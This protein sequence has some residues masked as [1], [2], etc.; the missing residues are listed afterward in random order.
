[1]RKKIILI[2]V[3]L[4]CCIVMLSSCTAF[5]PKRTPEIEVTSITVTSDSNVTI[6]D[7]SLGTLQMIAVVLPTNATDLSVIWSVL[8]GT[9]IA[10]INSSGLLTAFSNG[11]VTVVATSVGTHTISGT[12]EITITNQ[13]STDETIESDHYTLSDL[14]SDYD[15]FVHNLESN[16][17]IFSNE[18]ELAEIIQSQRQLLRNDMTQ[19]EF[20]RVLAVVIAAVRCGHSLVRV[21]Q[22][23]ILEIFDSEKAY[24]IDVRLINQQLMVIGIDG[25]TDIEFGDEILSI[26]GRS[27]QDITLEMMRY[28]NADGEGI[29]LK[30]WALSQ[31][32]LAYYRLFLGS[33]EA[34]LIE[35]L[36]Q[37]TGNHINT[38][39]TRNCSNIHVWVEEPPYEATYE[40]DYAILTLRT[41][42]PEGNYAL[43][44]FYLFFNEF[45]QRIETLGIEKVILDLRGNGG[46]DPRVASKLLSYLT[47]SPVPYLDRSSPDYYPGLKNPIPLSEP[48]F[49]GTLIT[50]IDAQCFSTCGHF[51]ALLKYHH[52][53]IM[54]G[55]ETGGGYICSDGSVNYILR[56]TRMEMRTSTMVWTVAVEGMSLG[57][58]SI[59]DIE[60][61]KSLEDYHHD[62]DRVLL[63]ALNW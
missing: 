16:P 53:G 26:N 41:F 10:T 25:E 31:S 56:N 11:T 2:P 30:T 8:P 29:S 59:P 23:I 1:M 35:Y 27:V 43:N 49:V 24:P 45:F 20:Y 17:K 63:T 12:K 47:S 62:V 9:G 46:G 28:L 18:A 42:Y 55:E 32:Y 19:L 60:V 33:K 4:F 6:I 15:Q 7:T 14:Q 13:D 57:R 5:M 50:L 44:D 39:L 58:G 22:P 40:D 37:S 21:P 52:I 3:I 38:I 34:I 51:T 54:M 48:H 36:D 61:Q